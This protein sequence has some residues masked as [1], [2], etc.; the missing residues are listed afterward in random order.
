MKN[1][2]RYLKKKNFRVNDIYQKKISINNIIYVLNEEEMTSSIINGRK[3]SGKI[4]I[5]RSINYENKEYIVTSILNRAFYLS[6]IKDVFFSDDSEL[7]LIEKE[8]FTNCSIQSISIP[9]HVTEIGDKAFYNSSRFKNIHFSD[10]SELKTI[11]VAS[12]SSTI[13]ESISIPSSLIEIKEFSF[14]NCCL[15]NEVIIPCN[16]KLQYIGEKAFINTI[17]NSFYIPDD[18]KELKSACL[19]SIHLTDIKISPKN[20]K[21]SIWDDQIVVEKSGKNNDTFDV[22]VFAKRDIINIRI[23]KFIE[24]IEP[25]A[26]NSC[27]HLKNIDFEENSQLKSIGTSS[28]SGSSIASIS[29]PKSVSEISAE[30]FSCCEYLRIFEIPENSKIEKINWSIFISTYIDIFLIPPDFIR[31]IN[32]NLKDIYG[33]Y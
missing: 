21:F 20:K 12:F 14:A 13:I 26:F 30:A 11:G 7:K 24:K 5:P 27:V 16:S 31:K 18:L 32:D 2:K 8:A 15:L 33:T 17:I 29:I 1:M 19:S 23:P 3:G 25:F 28:F 9:V 4:I 22:I 10:N 6:K